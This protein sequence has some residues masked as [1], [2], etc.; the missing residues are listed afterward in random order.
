MP[1]RFTDLFLAFIAGGLGLVLMACKPEPMA[2]PIPPLVEGAAPPASTPAAPLPAPAAPVRTDIEKRERVADPGELQ[3]RYLATEDVSARAE[4]V[5]NLWEIGTPVA[6]EILRGLFA[7]ERN[8]DLKVDMVSGMVEEEAEPTGG[9]RWML[10]LAAVGTGQPDI[11][12]L[13][14]VQIAAESKDPRAMPLLQGLASD[15]DEEV[16]EAAVAALAERRDAATR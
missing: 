16:R 5:A 15:G 6:V 8:A 3:S 11:V 14:A 7:T 2:R 9:P 13:V 4:I 10:L 1:N 12:R